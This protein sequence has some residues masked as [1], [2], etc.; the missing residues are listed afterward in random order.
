MDPPGQ[1]MFDPHAWILVPTHPSIQHP[2]RYVE[3]W[4]IR[5]TTVREANEGNQKIQVHPPPGKMRLQGEGAQTVQMNI[6]GNAH[7][8]GVINLDTF[9]PNVW[10]DMTARS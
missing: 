1:R 3:A 2:A 7:A 5:Q 4:T 6:Q 10:P 8:D 9:H